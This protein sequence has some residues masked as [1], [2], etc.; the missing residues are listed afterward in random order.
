[1]V[2]DAGDETDD[3]IVASLPTA[4]QV[5]FIVPMPPV[6]GIGGLSGTKSN[7]KALGFGGLGEEHEATITFNTQFS[8]DFDN[9]NGVDPGSMD[10]ETVA[11]HELGHALGFI[12]EVDYIADLIEWELQGVIWP[13]TLDLFRF[14]NDQAGRDPETPAEFTTYPRSMALGGDPITDTLDTVWGTLDFV[15]DPGEFRMSN[16]VDGQQA[17]HWKDDALSGSYIG[18]MDPT[19]SLGTIHVVDEPDLRALDLIGYEIMAAGP[20]QWNL[21]GGGS[22]NDPANWTNQTVPDGVGAVPNFVGS[23]T[24]ASTVTVDSPVTVGTIN[25]DN[26]NSYTIAGPGGITFSASVGDAEINVVEGDHTISAPVSAAGDLTVDT[27][28]ETT[29]TIETETGY[30]VLQGALTKD[31][32]GS[33]ALGGSLIVL[34]AVDHN[35]GVLEAGPGVG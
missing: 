2:D 32:S 19:L 25:F 20:N 30:S 18:L 34:G 16:V 15:G 35:G 13:S 22:Y 33:L 7:F 6:T 24:Q 9:S 27:A 4:A 14:E 10:F 26:A 28:D 31:G 8:F 21:P 1:M 17:S 5:S 12:S 29:L 23:I 11:A 3:G